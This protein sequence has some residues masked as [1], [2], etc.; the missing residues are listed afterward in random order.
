[1]E[2]HVIICCMLLIVLGGCSTYGTKPDEVRPEVQMQPVTIVKPTYSPGSLWPGET[3]RN[4]FFSDNKARNVNDIITIVIVESSSGQN[5]ASTNSSRDTSTKAGISAMLGLDTQILNNNPSMG[6]TISIGGSHA[7]S[8]KGT[9]DT[10]RGGTLQATI[11]ARVV[12]VLENGNLL[13]EGRR[14][15]TLNEEDQFIVMTGI[16]RQ[17]DITID[18]QVSSSLI[19]D[20]RIVYTGSGVIN[21]KQ[22]PGWLTRILDWGWPF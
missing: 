20:A 10:S 17:D 12:R 21:D 8:L 22:R 2:K 16:V 4:S 5:K 6:P 15:L 3:N 11:T 7:N 9:G 18:N 13:I 14:Q 1:M 19:A